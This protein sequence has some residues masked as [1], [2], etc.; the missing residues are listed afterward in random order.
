[1]K[2][3]APREGKEGRSNVHCGYGSPK[4]ERQLLPRATTELAGGFLVIAGVPRGCVEQPPQLIGARM[5]IGQYIF[6]GNFWGNRGM[7]LLPLP[8][9]LARWPFLPSCD[10]DPVRR[11]CRGCACPSVVRI[12][13]DFAQPRFQPALITQVHDFSEFARHTREGIEHFTLRGDQCLT[14]EVE[15]DFMQAPFNRGW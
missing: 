9:F 2:V 3:V 13:N 10:A 6:K 15:H 11:S 8:G 7:M 1:M 4:G 5:Q 14:R 12:H